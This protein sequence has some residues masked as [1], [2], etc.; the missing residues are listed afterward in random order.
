MA[1]QEATSNTPHG[2]KWK[3]GRIFPPLYLATVLAFFP[4][5]AL[6]PARAQY[7]NY[8]ENYNTELAVSRL[9]SKGYSQLNAGHYEAAISTL[10]QALRCGPTRYQ[11]DILAAI[12]SAH[13]GL[14]QYPQAIS[15]LRESL[16][17]NPREKGAYYTF[18]IVYYEQKRYDDALAALER[19]K[20]LAKDHKEEKKA[21]DFI[22]DIQCYRHLMPAQEALFAGRKLEAKELLLK[23]AQQDPSPVSGAVH[24]MLAHAY[25]G[26]G[27]SEQ[28]I[29][30]G[31]M[32]LQFEPRNKSINYVIGLCYKDLGKIDEA[33][34]YVKRFAQ[35][36]SDP[37]ERQ[38]AREFIQD[39]ED[40]R[41]KLSDTS[42]GLPDYF[43]LLLSQGQLHPW[44]QSR[45]P[46]KIFVSDGTGMKGYRSNFPSF[47]TKSLDNW[48]K[49][50]GNKLSYQ[51]VDNAAQ[52]DIQVEWT[53]D[54][55][56]KEEEGRKRAAAGITANQ[57]EHNGN[58][59]WNI[60]HSQIRIQTFDC[61][62]GDDCTDDDM[63]STCLH[64]IGHSLGLC[65]HSANYSDIMYFGATNRQLPAATKRD[66]ATMGKLY[67]HYQSRL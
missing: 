38:K 2:Q 28:A 14:K 43:H 26:M 63:Y 56:F 48:V 32:A 3:G 41:V 57:P 17:V 46:L 7:Q 36:E 52:A 50:S 60:G 4:A 31:Q 22:K 13:R 44:S 33:I 12:G 23:A 19:Y 8:Q 59:P 9:I 40:D 42:N 18:A 47:I 61:L 64:E 67:E 37:N 5:S 6:S 15:A 58:T 54:Y 16:K 53:E 21:D 55:L 27:N 11:A 39:L 20:M 34:A 45:M 30:E 10:S 66:K 49:A 24:R 51:I 65:G 29:V 1:R 35:A 25:R 62:S